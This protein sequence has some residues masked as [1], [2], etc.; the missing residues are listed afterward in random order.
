MVSIKHKLI[1]RVEMMIWIR[2]KVRVR[3]TLEH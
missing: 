3:A 2:V 1:I